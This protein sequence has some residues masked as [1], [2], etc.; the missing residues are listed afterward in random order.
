MPDA[1]ERASRWRRLACRPSRLRVGDSWRG[2]GCG[3]CRG[4]GYKGRKAVAEVLLLDDELREL[5]A[6]KA[7]I[8]TLKDCAAKAGLRSLHGAALQ[9]V[10]RGETTLEEV[11]RV[12]G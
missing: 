6:S 7:P 9:W 10:A 5:I 8:S 11:G 3:H 4:T 2:E 12:A 1:A